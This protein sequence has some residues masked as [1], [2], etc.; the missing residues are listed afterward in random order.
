MILVQDSVPNSWGR[1]LL[2]PAVSDNVP[3]PMTGGWKEL[4]LWAKLSVWADGC[5]WFSLQCRAAF[6]S[7]PSKQTFLLTYNRG[8]NVSL[9]VLRDRLQPS[10][11]HSESCLEGC[12][13]PV[14]VRWKVLPGT[15]DSRKLFGLE[16]GTIW[17]V[18][19]WPKENLEEPW[20]RDLSKFTLHFG[21]GFPGILNC[22]TFP[23]LAIIIL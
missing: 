17:G 16:M 21:L 3:L 14:S 7:K 8:Q 22:H 20:R 23:Q 5:S 19:P 4:F 10:L 2:F 9:L 11:G 1:W 13:L 18:L 6:T 12:F 15:R